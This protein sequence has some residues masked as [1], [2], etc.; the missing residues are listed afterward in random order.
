MLEHGHLPEEKRSGYNLEWP[1]G[2]GPPLCLSKTG[3]GGGPT[4]R[5]L[6]HSVA[7]SNS[8]SFPGWWRVARDSSPSLGRMVHT[9]AVQSSSS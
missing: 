4:L 2:P 8:A 7:F 5:A 9:T 1:N 6:M 3:P